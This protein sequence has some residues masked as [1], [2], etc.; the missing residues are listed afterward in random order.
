MPEPW[1][2]REPPQRPYRPPTQA[3][4]RSGYSQD[5]HL[6]RLGFQ[7]TGTLAA[8]ESS[9]GQ[10]QPQPYVPQPSQPPRQSSPGTARRI[11][12]DAAWF[13]SAAVVAFAAGWAGLALHSGSTPA[14]GGTKTAAVGSAINL[15]GS[16]SGQQMTVTVVRVIASA[17]RGEIDVAPAGDRLYAVQFRLADTGS[18]PYSD[19]P[20]NGAVVTD[21]S[22]QSYR[23]SGIDEAAGCRSFPAVEHLAHGS[24]GLGWIVFEVPEKAKISQVQFTLDSGMGPQTGQ[25]EAG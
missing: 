20:T 11:A 13:A 16:F 10:W 14:V 9:Y 25:W 7:P 17:R 1:T 4:P 2:Y 22:G 8:T 5:V 12:A 18:A 6:E 19:A 15:A 3:V 24:S 21:S 23:A